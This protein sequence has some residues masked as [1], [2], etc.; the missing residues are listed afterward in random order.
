M[1]G[2]E[3]VRDWGFDIVLAALLA[4]LCWDAHSVRQCRLECSRD[5]AYQACVEVCK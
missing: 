4:Y 3:P 5:R 2:G 1:R